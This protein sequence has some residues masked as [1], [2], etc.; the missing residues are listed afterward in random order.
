VTSRTTTGGRTITRRFE[1]D[2]VLRNR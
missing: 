2:V 1:T